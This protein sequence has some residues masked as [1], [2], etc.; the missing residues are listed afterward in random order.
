[1]DRGSACALDTWAG[2]LVANVTDSGQTWNRGPDPTLLLAMAPAIDLA[3]QVGRTAAR[4][5]NANDLTIGLALQVGR[6]A[7]RQKWNGLDVRTLYAAG[8]PKGSVG[9][10][11]RQ[12][13]FVSP[14]ATDVRGMGLPWCDGCARDGGGVKA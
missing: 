10:R 3:L 13:L 12:E 8:R 11:V 14:G 4:Q 2:R 5:L 1:M 9:R 6:T 7:A